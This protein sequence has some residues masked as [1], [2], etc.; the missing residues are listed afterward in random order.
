WRPRYKTR[1]VPCH[2]KVDGA[3]A[4]D[5]WLNQES[6]RVSVMSEQLVLLAC[7]V[8]A[9][10]GVPGLF[11]GRHST[12]AHWLEV[13]LAVTG[14]VLGIFGAMKALAGDSTAINLPWA[15]PGGEFAVAVDGISVAFLLP[16]FVISML[17]SIYGLGYWPQREHL[18]NG[19]K[20]RL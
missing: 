11:L 18:E 7:A 8:T 17:G 6:T 10:S 16:I 5:P 1:E 3:S 4:L 2:K 13:M 9:C 20:L 12:V 14:S 19:R 15:V